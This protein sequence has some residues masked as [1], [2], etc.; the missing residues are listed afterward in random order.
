[1]TY[2]GSYEVFAVAK[3]LEGRYPQHIL[4]FYKS[5]LG[6]LNVSTSRK[7]YAQNA[8]AVARI[9]RVLVD[10]MKK[11]DEWK[12]FA[13]PIKLHNTKRPAF[14]DEFAKV[15]PDWKSL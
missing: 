7:I 1:M 4:E 6:N 10:V 14:Q 2:Y 9:R 12:K 8:V 5:S 3:E 15:I 11:P 13:L